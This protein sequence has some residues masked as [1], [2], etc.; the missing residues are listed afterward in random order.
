MLVVEEQEDLELL[1][2]QLLVVILQ[3]PLH[4]EFQHYQFVHKLIQ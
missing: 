1:L 2:E 4:Q 3:D